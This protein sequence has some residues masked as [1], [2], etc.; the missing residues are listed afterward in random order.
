MPAGRPTRIGPVCERHRCQHSADAHSLRRHARAARRGSC[1]STV[2]QKGSFQPHPADIYNPLPLRRRDH[3]PQRTVSAAELRHA[4]CPL[5]GDRP[6]RAPFARPNGI[7]RPAR[8]PARA[9]TLAPTI[10]PSTGGGRFK[11]GQACGDGTVPVDRTGARVEGTRA[12]GRVHSGP[13]DCRGGRS[14]LGLVPC[15]AFNLSTVTADTI[16]RPLCDS[17]AVPRVWTRVQRHHLV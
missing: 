3:Q 17:P 5:K 11:C 12:R 8:L 4:S 16:R 14:G 6:A 9:G 7:P 10:T 2:A 13:W 15:L 1:R